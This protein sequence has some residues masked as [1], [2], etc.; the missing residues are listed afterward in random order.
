MDKSVSEDPRKTQH[1]HVE[2]RRSYC[3]QGVIQLYGDAGGGGGGGGGVRR[4]SR[5]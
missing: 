3:F 5:D 4:T 1:S 2:G